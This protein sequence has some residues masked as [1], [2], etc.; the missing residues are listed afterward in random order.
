[1]NVN[2]LIL[3]AGESSRLGQPKQLVK[4]NNIHLVNSIENQLS[5]LCQ[6]VYM[7]LGANYQII[8]NHIK[9]AEVIHNKH[10]QQ[11]M[12][13]SLSCGILHAKDDAEGILIALSDQPLIPQC[14]YQ[15][16]LETFKKKPEHIIA[17]QYANILGVPAV[18]P[19]SFFDAL[20]NKCSINQGAQSIIKNNRDRVYPVPCEL[21]EFDLDTPEQLKT[22]QILSKK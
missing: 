8:V 12:H 14:H 19:Q 11:G 7:V 6:K 4:Y 1:M 20:Q 15:I 10:W 13:S 16:L 2:G 22:L 21:A 3:A 18:F 5:H 9:K 17:T